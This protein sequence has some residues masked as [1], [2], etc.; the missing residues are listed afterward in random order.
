MILL[1]YKITDK[2][3]RKKIIVSWEYFDKTDN[4]IMK[5]DQIVEWGYEYVAKS[6]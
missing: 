6:A 4:D 3:C 5:R 1:N 2:K